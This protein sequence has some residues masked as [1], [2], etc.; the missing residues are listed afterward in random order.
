M[1]IDPDDLKTA[2]GQPARASVEM[3]ASLEEAPNTM[4][5]YDGGLVGVTRDGQTLGVLTTD[6]VHKALR[7]SV[8]QP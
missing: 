6:S 2:N 1:T 4:M 3:P 5:R 8:S 7:R